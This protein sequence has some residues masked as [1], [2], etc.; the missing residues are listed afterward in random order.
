MTNMVCRNI[1]LLSFNIFAPLNES[2]AKISN[3]GWQ[4]PYL[5]SEFSVQ[6]YWS[7]SKT[8]WYSRVEPTS[9]YKSQY[10]Q[11]QF[12]AIKA[13]RQKCLGA[14][15]FVWG[16]KQ[17][18]T[19][20]WFS[21]FSPWPQMHETELSDE[22]R[23]EW[24][25]Q[26]PARTAPG[27][28]WVTID[29]LTDVQN[30]YL[31]PGEATNVAVHTVRKVAGPLQLRWELQEEVPEYLISSYKTQKMKVLADSVWQQRPTG[32]AISKTGTDSADTY[33]FRFRAP[34]REGPYRLYLYL[35]TADKKVST[36]NACFFVQKK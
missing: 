28:D 3:C 5:V 1:D 11:A 2:L 12:S 32:T 35:A 15:V 13:N 17:E 24:T 18:Y 6:G 4:G 27:I 33:T 29:N 36:A 34:D 20:T 22:C 26:K 7:T 31:K 30:I 19:P 23:Q 21:L 14:Y 9:Y 10:L 16:T 8:D 25:G